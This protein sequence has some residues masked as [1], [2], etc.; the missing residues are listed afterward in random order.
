VCLLAAAVALHKSNIVK[1]RVFKKRENFTTQWYINKIA[2]K[3]V[4]RSVFL[5][6]WHF[7]F[8]INKNALLLTAFF[9]IL[10]TGY[11]WVSFTL[12]LPAKWYHWE[13]LFVLFSMDLKP[14]A[15]ISKC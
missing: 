3:A 13:G 9:S 4:Y 10:P 1:N 6:I 11:R 5:T 12:L 14:S 2:K 7:E 15:F 8:R